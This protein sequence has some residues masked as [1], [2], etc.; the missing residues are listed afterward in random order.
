MHKAM[1]RVTLAVLALVLP[2]AALGA[3]PPLRVGV[4]NDMS[5][6]Y[7]DIAGPGSVTAARMAVEDFGGAVLGRSIKILV[8]DHQNKP[9]IGSVIAR[10][11]YDREGVGL[12]VDVPTSSV[13][14]AVN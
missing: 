1:H 2:V 14:L 8:G 6:I 3:A 12:I 7:A 11:W 9:D 4:L 10:R 5:G 13:V